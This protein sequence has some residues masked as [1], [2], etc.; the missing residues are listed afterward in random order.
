MSR[1]RDNAPIGY[2]C[3]Q[4]NEVIGF[5]ESIQW[6]ETETELAKECSSMLNVMEEI[7]TANDTL[8]TWGNELYNEKIEIED[9]RDDLNKVI[10]KLQ[11]DISDLQDEKDS[12]YE[13]NCS[14]QEQINEL[15]N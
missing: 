14:L 15:Y 13:E 2:T 1:N 4:I 8:R 9:D 10:E 7:R 3:N 6:D 5:L 11:S 12:L